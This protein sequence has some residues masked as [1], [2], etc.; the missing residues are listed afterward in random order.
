M[1]KKLLNQATLEL[2]IQTQGPLL[3]K[4]GIEGGADP[5]VPDM[6]FVRSGGQVYIPGSSLKG[7]VRSYAE[8]IARTVNPDAKRDWCCDPFDDNPNSSTCSCSRHTRVIEERVGHHERRR[9]TSAEK[10]KRRDC[11]C[12]ICQVFGSTALASRIKFNDAYATDGHDPMTETRTSVAIDRILGSVA[13]GPF[14]F[15]VVTTA[16]FKTSI[17]LRNFELW[18]LGLLA[19]VVRDL[20]EGLIPIGF[21]KSRGLGEV[22]AKVQ[23]FSVR[24]ISVAADVPTNAPHALYGIGCLATDEDREAYWSLTE[25]PA[26]DTIS[27]E[28]EGSLRP[29]GLGVCVTFDDAVRQEVFRKCVKERWREVLRHDRRG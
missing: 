28:A 6:Q 18:Q 11:T 12:R 1:L 25:N 8:K 9:L 22:E 7:V 29:E 13:Q 3:I 26:G 4:S 24:Y 5:S 27:L 2:T 21:G 19:L 10:Y 17:H 16:S 14:D 23:S 15:E 20:E